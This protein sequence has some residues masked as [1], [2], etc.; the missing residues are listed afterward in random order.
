VNRREIRREGCGS[1]LKEGRE[2]KGRGVLRRLQ[3]AWGEGCG[4]EAYRRRGNKMKAEYVED[5]R[6]GGRG[7]VRLAGV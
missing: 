3:E 6:L 1:A 5:R 4:E 7:G 2:D